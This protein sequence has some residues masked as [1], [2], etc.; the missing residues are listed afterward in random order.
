MSHEITETDHMVSANGVMP[1]HK[2]G[3]VVEGALTAEAA[4]AQAKLNWEVVKRRIR[5]SDGKSFPDHYGI[6]RADT[7]DPL[8]IVGSRYTPIQNTDGLNILDPVI[9]EDAVYETAG[10]LRGGKIVWFLAS[11][12][13]DY[14]LSGKSDSMKQY[15]LVYLSHD[16][17]KPVTVR[18]VSTRVVC[19]NT[20][21]AAVGEAKAMVVIRHTKNFKDRIDEAHRI[22]GLADKHAQEFQKVYGQLQASK[23]SEK[24]A[25]DFL[26]VWMPGDGKRVTNT[27]VKMFDL[28]RGGIGN[29]G[30]TR[31]DMFN[32]VTQFLSHERPVRGAN[33]KD[34]P[35]ALARAAE[36][37]F[38]T[39]MIGYGINMQ[40]EAINLLLN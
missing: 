40:A 39:N 6:V 34:N 9:G 15:F 4:L 14:F 26:T 16:G 8:G 37:R 7:G 33:K 1:W 22:V 29:E 32:A 38:E 5:V 12:K 28:F 30:K 25:T 17:T 3:T 10:S 27:R 36:S 23:M 35:K 13:K 2:L 19:M 24:Q 31:V 20:L 11:L 18:F 21:S